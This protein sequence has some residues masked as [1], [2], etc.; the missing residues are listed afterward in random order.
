MEGGVFPCAIPKHAFIV[1]LVVQNKLLT[2][3]QLIKWGYKGEVKCLSVT[4]KL[5]A[6]CTCFLSVA[7]VIESG[8]FVCKDAKKTI[9]LLH[10]MKF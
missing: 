9:L 10:G 6:R 2:G 1:W 7:S 4:I 8:N 5:K 3:D